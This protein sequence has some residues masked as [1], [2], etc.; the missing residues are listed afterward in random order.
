MKEK[1]IYYTKEILL[2]ILVITIFAN[3]ISFYKSQ[4]LNKQP[5]KLQSIKLFNNTIYTME[6]DEPLLI[7]FWATW[8]PTCKMEVDNIQR[9]SKH[10][11]VLTFAVKSGSDYDIYQYMQERGLDFPVVNDKDGSFAQEFHINA[12]P[13]TFIYDKNHNLIFSEVGYTSSIGL[14]LR[15]LWASY[16]PK[17]N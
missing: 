6:K 8:C 4:E 9:I 16:F 15:M 5:L 2:F 17:D 3:G 7:H 14:Y 11:N 1:F 13:T 10:Y 12:Y